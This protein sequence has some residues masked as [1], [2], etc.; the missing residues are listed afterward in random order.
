MELSLDRLRQLVRPAPGEESAAADQADLL[1]FLREQQSAGKVVL[2][3]S[4]YDR[5]SLFIHAVLVPRGNLQDSWE[6]VTDWSG[7]PFDCVSCGL[8]YGGRQGPR[9]QMYSPWLDRQPAILRTAMQLV[10][11]RSFDAR[12][13]PRRYFEL[14][15][16]ITHA[17]GLHWLEERQAWCRLNDEGDVVDMAKLEEHESPDGKSV[18]LVWIDRQLMDMHMAASGTCIAQMFDS[19]RIPATFQG[20]THSGYQEHLDPEKAIAYKC[21]IEGPSSYFRGMQFILPAASANQWGQSE[22]DREHGTKEY[23]SFIIQDWKNGRVIEWSCAPEALASYFDK[24]SEL[25]F[26]TS[27]VFFKPQ[28][29]EKYKADREKYTLDD[30][31]ITCRNAWHLE[32]YDVN[33]AGQVHTY[34]TYLNRLPL[35]EQRYW[36]SF[37]EKPKA[38]ISRRAFQTDFEGSWDTQPDAL[39]ELKN[40]LT[41][42]R[43]N[44]PA[45]FRVRQPDLVGQLHYPLT[46]AFKPWDDTLID[47]AKTAVE[48]LERSWFVSIVKKHGSA[49][50][51][52]WGSVRWLREALLASGVDETRVRELIAPLEEI[53]LLRT[54]LAAHAGGT[55]ATDIRRKLLR[56]HG[57]PK[58][59]IE[60][61]SARLNASLVGVAEILA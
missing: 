44:A 41:D 39:R 42:L 25:P 45:W 56:D 13:G 24:G 61:I 5:W 52:K 12:I 51:P 50:D 1:A 60:A 21:S 48:G 6:R 18:T 43:R 37:N 28:V 20:F 2:Y 55:E 19:T 59:H 4:G 23:E 14:A 29:L 53:Q 35:Q 27:P 36:K 57:T 30:R 26:Q 33:D 22:Y 31:S 16:E 9:I 32:T 15:Q 34:I 11:G 38:A 8:V 10:F 17:H 40:T 3:A 7:N 47:L 58:A 49:G 54:K 46:S